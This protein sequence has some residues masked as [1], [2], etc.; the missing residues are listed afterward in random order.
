MCQCEECGCI[1]N[2]DFSKYKMTPRIQIFLFKDCIKIITYIHDIDA[3][4]T[5]TERNIK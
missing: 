1:E 4:R 5:K 3:L 2:T